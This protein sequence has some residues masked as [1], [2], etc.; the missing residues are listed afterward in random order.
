MAP[1]RHW[2]YTPEKG[3]HWYQ[4]PAEKFAPLY[5]FVRRHTPLFDDYETYADLALVMPHRAFLK[6]P[7]RWFTFAARLTA[8]NLSYR[9]IL[10]GD[11]IVDH[12]I[13]AEELDS[14]KALFIPDRD[15]LLPT[16]RALVEKAILNRHVYATVEEVIL[17]VRP[18]VQ[19][20]ASVPVRAWPRVKAGA[21]AIHLLNYDYDPGRDDVRPAQGV[22]VSIDTKALGIAA[23]AIGRLVAA[24]APETKVAP[25]AGTAELPS[26]AL[27]SLLLLETSP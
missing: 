18:T 4:G 13:R 15:E 19:V 27:W 3:T 6:N 21:V 5:Q 14:A 12:P 11:E 17:A 7:N 22:S 24:D 2:C 23:D 10:G 26:L 9:L 20:R 8:T 25:K 1:H 16:D